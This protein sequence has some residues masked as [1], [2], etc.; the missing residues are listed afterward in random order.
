MGEERFFVYRNL[1]TG[2]W[3]LRNSRGIVISHPKEIIIKDPTFVVQPSGLRRVR[4]SGRKVV[5]AGVRGEVVPLSE[6]AE[7]HL[8]SKAERV[9]Y[10][11]MRLD[12]FVKVSDGTPVFKGRFAILREDKS[13][14]VVACDE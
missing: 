4:E 2:T 8:L 12:H 5:H 11:P 10:N 7:S 9:T 13:V 6:E 14:Y 1:R 3:S